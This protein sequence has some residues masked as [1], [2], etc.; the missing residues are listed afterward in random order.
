MS[1]EIFYGEVAWFQP[2]K[3]YGFILWEK[4]G[5]PQKDI[6]VHFSDI[7]VEGFKTVYKH[8]KVSFSI[9]VNKRN[10]PKAINVT[11]LHN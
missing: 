2:K 9:G 8:Q 11:I 6:F 1:E 4:D 10:D 3:G 7:N 5:V